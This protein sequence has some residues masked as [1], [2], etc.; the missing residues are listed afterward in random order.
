M[1]DSLRNNQRRAILTGGTGFI[2]SHLARKLLQSGWQVCLLVRSNSRRE[3]LEALGE[4]VL[5]EV[6]DQ[7]SQR[8]LEIF[9]RFRPLAVFHLASSMKLEQR[10]VEIDDMIHSNILFGTHLLEGMLRSGGLYFVNTGSYWQHFEGKGYNPVNF[11]AATKQAFEDLLKYYQ[12]ATPIRA[13][14]LKLFDTYGPGDSREKLFQLLDRAQQTGESLAMT[15]GEQL[16]DLVYIDDVVD[17]FCQAE[18]LLESSP[19]GSLESAY[20]VSSNRRIPLKNVVQVYERVTGKK[21]NI[22]WGGRPYGKRQVMT[23]WRGTLLP[24]WKP[25]V[26]LEAGIRRMTVEREWANV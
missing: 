1:E 3:K 18:K 10:T 5:F 6:Y 4:Q 25:K 24:G 14:T 12:E 11:Y 19:Q 7:N 22:Q 9:D 20:A 8:L 17:A 16:M 21:L 26:D 13:V 15:P 2:G 23:P